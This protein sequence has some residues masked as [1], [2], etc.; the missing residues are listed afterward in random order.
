MTYWN[1]LININSI[2][3]KLTN[4]CFRLI[5]LIN[6][7]QR[8]ILKKQ[9]PPKLSHSESD[10][11]IVLNAPS[12]CNQDLSLLNG[13]DII[14][15]NRGF[16]H[17]LFQSLSP[18]YHIIIDPKILTGDWP[19]SWLDEIISM[20]PD[21]KIVLPLQWSSLKLFKPYTSNIIWLDLK[22][23]FSALGVSGACFEF[24]I[25]QNYKKIYF[26]GFDGNGIAHEMIK[27]QSHFYGYNEENNTKSTKNYII[28]LFMHSRQFTELHKFAIKAKKKK[29]DIV[30]IT[31]GGLID[32]FPREK[33]S[34][35][36]KSK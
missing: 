30:N 2:I 18:K 7:K 14:F 22:K 15:V 3:I 1:L 31:D 28:D 5:H 35:I 21:I 8:R 32:M 16:K 13:K 19:I 11:F 29:I 33:L 27:S 36:N 26:T 9:I 6:L 17:N 34:D 23:R 25:I 12:I 24:A 10:V 20:T 4:I